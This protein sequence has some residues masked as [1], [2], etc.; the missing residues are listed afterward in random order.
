MK[1]TYLKSAWK[2]ISFDDSFVIKLSSFLEFHLPLGW[3][4]PS[5]QFVSTNCLILW[6][7]QQDNLCWKCLWWPYRKKREMEM[8]IQTLINRERLSWESSTIYFQDLWILHSE[9]P[10][11]R[12]NV[13]LSAIKL[14]TKTNNVNK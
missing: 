8:E 5:L 9:T 10:L 11:C 12:Y 6:L 14:I 3:V 2:L 7:L 1:L 13:D 4:D